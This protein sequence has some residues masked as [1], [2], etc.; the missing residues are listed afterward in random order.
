[1]MDVLRFAADVRAR[2]KEMNLTQFVAA[3]F[4]EIQPRTLQKIEKGHLPKVEIF[5]RICELYDLNV[6]SYYKGDP[7]SVSVS[8]C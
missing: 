4:L 7:K 2:R 3:E 1:M 8:A 5:F 6:R